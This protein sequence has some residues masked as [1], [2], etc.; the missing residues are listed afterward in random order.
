MEEEVEAIEILHNPNDQELYFRFI[1]TAKRRQFV[2]NVRFEG[3]D[4]A[5]GEQLRPEE[6]D[7]MISKVLRLVL[8]QIGER[9]NPALN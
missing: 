8:A 4:S 2:V 5:T 9:P 1:G 6:F 3:A 7:F